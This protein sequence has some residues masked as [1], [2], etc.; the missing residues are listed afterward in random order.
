MNILL[1][2]LYLLIIVY[3]FAFKK[4]KAG[5][6]LAFLMAWVLIAGNYDNADYDQYLLRYESGLEVTVDIGYSC[7]CNF[8]CNLGFDYQTFKGI[9]SFVCLLMIYRTI[10]KLSLH[11]SVGAALFLIF[12]FIIDITQFRNF[13]SYS[14]VFSAIPHLFDNKRFGLIK[15]VAIVLLASSIHAA[16]IFYLVFALSKIKVKVWYVIVIALFVYLVKEAMKGYFS[17]R[18]DTQKLENLTQ[19]TMLGAI[20][21]SLVVI[22]N[23]L[24]IRYVHKGYNYKKPIPAKMPQRALAFC[25]DN[26]WL[27]CNMLLLLIIPF[28]FDN[29]NY[30]RI[31]RNIVV[32]NMI[33][34]YN[35]YYL[36][37]QKRYVLMLCYYAYF[38]FTTYL[39]GSYFS[40]IF[41][42]VFYNNSFFKVI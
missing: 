15:Y 41:A 14:V 27:Y 38:V 10:N 23:F 1:F 25:T 12:P 40:D 37:K 4:I 28:L 30:S 34:I 22:I 31:Y 6:Y 3:C 19:T 33:F 24:L 11:P 21:G 35:A 5:F 9:V 26:T 8:F 2:I 7:L 29:G 20:A 39:Q 17:I 13:V 42:P 32:L 16:S 36:N 18:L